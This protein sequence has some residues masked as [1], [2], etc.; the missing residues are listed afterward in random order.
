M[1]TLQILYLTL[2]KLPYDSPLAKTSDD[3]PADNIL[4]GNPHILYVPYENIPDEY[5]L[6]NIL[7][8]NPTHTVRP[9]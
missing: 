6:Y 9:K 4:D 8:D 7:D 1:T 2:D 5:P 3:N